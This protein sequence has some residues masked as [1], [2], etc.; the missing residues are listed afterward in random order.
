MRVIGGSF[1]FHRKEFIELMYES[2]GLTRLFQNTN[3]KAEHRNRY[4]AKCF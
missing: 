3:K 1:F 4:S 2:C